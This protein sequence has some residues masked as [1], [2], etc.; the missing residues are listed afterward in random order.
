MKVNDIKVQ[1]TT[2]P[3][4]YLITAV[5]DKQIGVD[6]E[7][8][9]IYLHLTKPWNI[10]TTKQS[11]KQDIIGAFNEWK[12]QKDTEEAIRQELLGAIL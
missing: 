4:V 11:L 8:N 2:D 7:G 9:P 5:T 3:T 10:N 1:G 12:A 6:E